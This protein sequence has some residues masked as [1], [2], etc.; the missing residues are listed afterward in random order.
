[1]AKLGSY[2]ALCPLIDAKSLLGVSEDSEKG[3]AVVTLGKNIASRYKV[4][5]TIFTFHI[6]V[7][8]RNILDF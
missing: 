7:M 6:N 2:Y 1:M 5:Y 4:Y 3:F 8:V